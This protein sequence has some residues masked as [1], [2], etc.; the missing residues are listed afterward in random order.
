[1]DFRDKIKEPDELA[2]IINKLKEK[3]KKIIQC[4]GVFDLFHR[5]H[6]HQFEQAKKMGN[7]LIVSLTSDKFVNKGPGRPIFDQRIRAETIAAC[8][9]VD[10]V[11]FSNY[12]TAV[13]LINLFKPDVF[14][15]GASCSATD[16]DFSGGLEQKA[17][18]NI[19]GSMYFSEELPIHATPLINNYLDPYPENV[20]EFLRRFK[21]KFSAKQILEEINRLSRLRV[22][23]VGEAVIDQYDYVELLDIS[24]KGEVV[25]SKYL[26]TD[27]FAGGSLACANHIASFCNRVKLVT[28]IGSV[29]SYREFIESKLL[30][31]VHPH[32]LVRRGKSTIV[33]R[34]EVRKG[35]F[36]KHSE[37]YMFDDSLLSE[38]EEEELLGY[39]SNIYDYDLVFILD[40]GH[41][42][43]T[44]RIVEYLIKNSKFIAANTQMNSANKGFHDITKYPRLDFACIDHMEACLAL[45]NRHLRYEVLPDKL[46]D[47]IDVRNVA[48]TLGHRGSIIR[49]NREKY[50]IPAFSKKI[51]D[52]V[53]SGDAF[54]SL[55]SICL[56][57]NLDLELA[58]FIG[59]TAGALATT[60]LGNESFI[61]KKVLLNFIGSL[62]A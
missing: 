20:L 16:R 59:N 50:Y 48:V 29:N 26:E 39:L 21:E 34:R 9:L 13:E 10:F 60:Y 6:I 44:R 2:K 41:G 14:V 58:G 28:Y 19:G 32:F 49:N 54:F 3:D 53:G 56:C 37:T 61:D 7:V 25:A 35:Y 52:T 15:K 31:N 27:L 55:S 8:E 5:G 40:Y 42:F 62:L 51:V 18:N 23:V 33:K 38:V 57:A 17:V 4:H 43:I 12:P 46:S 1:M 30:K 47:L 36:Q 24:P 11:T 45:K 22:L